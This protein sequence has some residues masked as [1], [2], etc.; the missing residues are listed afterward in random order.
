MHAAPPRPIL[1]TRYS[2]LSS[3]SLPDVIND[4]YFLEYVGQE[5]DKL[6]ML[7]AMKMQTTVSAPVD[8]VVEEVLVNLGDTV[9][10]KD[11]LVRLRV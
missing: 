1:Y 5:G 4:E 7:E 11:L 9:E 2:I 8:A 10:S 6:L 3:P